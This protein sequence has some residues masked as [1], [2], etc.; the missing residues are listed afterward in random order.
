MMSVSNAQRAVIGTIQDIPTGL[1]R[2]CPNQPR[3]Y[4]EPSLLKELGASIKEEGQ[5]T[6]AWI[7]PVYDDPVIQY[8]LVAGERRWRA[9][10]SAGV[11][12][13]RAEIRPLEGRDQ[14]FIDSVM[15]NLG[16][17]GLAP[18]EIARSI[19][20]VRR[21][22]FGDLEW[23]DNV[24]ER[25][26]TVFPHSVAWINQY[27]RLIRL[28][29][30]VQEMMSPEIPDGQRLPFQVAIAIANLQPEAQREIA[31]RVIAEGMKPKRALAYV[32]ARVTNDMRVVR[33]GSLGHPRRP[34]DDFEI[35]SRF[36][37]SLGESAEA[38]LDMSH[39]KFEAMFRH[40]PPEELREVI[41]VFEERLSQLRDL[42]SALQ[43][44]VNSGTATSRP[45]LVRKAASAS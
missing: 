21:L 4:F 32:R 5:K 30:E 17:E 43:R 35:L 44:V 23:G 20:E 31:G 12:T 1:I 40:R 33:K 7:I 39:A 34:S 19:E 14:Q 9:C 15:E 6:P 41:A 8:E 11:P 29:P 2:P 45:V 18:L 22:R 13:L 16:R 24:A 25:L 38:L 26:T 10:R 27:R 36:L 42:R 37:A 3:K 28:C